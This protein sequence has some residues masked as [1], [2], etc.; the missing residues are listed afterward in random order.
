MGATGVD[1]LLSS[2]ALKLLPLSIEC[3][4]LHSIAV[5]KHYEQSQANKIEGTY[6]AVVIKQNRS[7][8]LILLSLKDFM[9]MR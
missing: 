7:D 6:P 3:K 5:Y 1:V 8:P 9:E 2:A 4:S